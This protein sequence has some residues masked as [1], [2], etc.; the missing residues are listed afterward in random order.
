MNLLSDRFMYTLTV[1][2]IHSEQNYNVWMYV[3]FLAWRHAWLCRFCCRFLYLVCWYIYWASSVRRHFLLKCLTL[4]AHHVSDRTSK[5]EI[6]S[7]IWQ[8]F[9]ALLDKMLYC[10][11]HFMFVCVR[12]LTT[13]FWFGFSLAF[14]YFVAVHNY[15]NCTTGVTYLLSFFWI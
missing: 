3:W 5:D 4:V 10:V 14:R 13:A 6:N 1:M 8:I 7:A 9:D 15:V 12:D 11:A 2:C